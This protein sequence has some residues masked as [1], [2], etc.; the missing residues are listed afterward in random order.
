MTY[1]ILSNEYSFSIAMDERGRILKVA[2]MGYSI[3]QRVGEIHLFKEKAQSSFALTFG[4]AAAGIAAACVLLVFTYYYM[5]LAPYSFVML[6][7]NPE[8]R[9]DV[10]RQN[11]VVAMIG[12]NEEGKDLLEGYS[13]RGKDLLLVTDEI[14]EKA[15]QAGYLADGSKITINI[16]SPDDVWFEETGVNMRKSLSAY[17]TERVVVTVEIYRDDQRN[18]DENPVEDGQSS[19]PPNH[20]NSSDYGAGDETETEYG[21]SDYDGD[22][23]DGLDR[24]DS[25]YDRSDYD[26]SDYDSSDYDD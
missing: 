19:A 16:H 12:L 3:G 18:S 24:D 1:L 4:A 20:Y 9:A 2:N 14:V 6:S 17:L 15:I 7:I 26:S 23:N 22:E 10:S 5:F 13:F 8:I 11:R 21:S 25:E